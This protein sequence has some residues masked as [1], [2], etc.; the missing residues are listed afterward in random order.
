MRSENEES[1]HQSES[2]KAKAA[3]KHAGK[4]AERPNEIRTG[5]PSKD[6]V[7]GEVQFK[8]PKGTKYRI[9]K[10]NEVDAYD[11]DPN[12]KNQT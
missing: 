2:R 8:S 1:A 4:R 11:V 7:V 9:L 10:T 3:T 12:K 6:S 5:M